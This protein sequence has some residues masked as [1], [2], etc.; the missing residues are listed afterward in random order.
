MPDVCI[1]TR[2]M[3]RGGC[4]RV[5]QQ[6]S[7]Y[8][9]RA[10][11]GV[12]LLLTED[13]PV[14]YAVPDGCRLTVIGTR[15]GN[16]LANKW[17][18][19]RALRRLIV[20]QRPGVV[21]AMPEEIGIF[22]V[23]AMCGTGVPVVVSERNNP[24]VMPNKRIT[25][26]LR[27][28][29]YPLAAGLIFQTEGAAGFFP[30]R[31]QKKGVVLPNPLDASRLGAP[32]DGEREKRVV[33]VGR[34][35]PQKNVPLLLHAFSDFLQRHP[36][37]VLDLY[38]EGRQE[39]ALR[40]LADSLLPK[41]AARFFGSCG[42]VSDRIRTAG[43]FVLPSDYEGMPNALM[44]AMALG[45]PCIATDCPTGGPAALI[46]HGVNG[47]LVP[48]GDAPAMAAAL[49]HLADEPVTA[50]KLGESARRIAGRLAIDRVAAEWAAYLASVIR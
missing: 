48:V 40:A 43:V 47:L 4:E 46:E 5:V 37:W 6:L 3:Q 25:R 17:M 9:L 19:Y 16:A 30:K 21:L 27:R 20:E 23:L 42:D 1:V 10:G 49:G 39:A 14:E 18:Q 38:G 13:R 12:H 29:A 7:A 36:G 24:F 35:E 11:W 15:S 32:W 41:E 2:S 28:I 26:L 8:L 22:T 50:N 44:E 33:Y 45:L 34:L 31:L